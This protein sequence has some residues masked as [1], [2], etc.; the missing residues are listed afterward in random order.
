FLGSTDM[1][2]FAPIINYQEN[3]PGKRLRNWSQYLFWNPSWNFD[4][5]LTFNGV[6]AI[7][8]FETSQFWSFFVRFDWRPPTL[9]DRMTRGGPLGAVPTRKGAQ[10]EF[11]TDRRKPYMFGGFLALST[12]AAGNQSTVIG[13]FLS[14]RPSTA[15]RL[16]LQ[17][18]ISHARDMAQYVLSVDDPTATATYGARYVFATLEQREFA[19]TTR[20][21]WTFTPNVSLQVFAQ[22]LIS[23]GDFFDYK[24]LARPRAYEFRVYGRDGGAIVPDNGGYFVAP[25]SGFPFSFDEPDFNGRFLRG[26]AVLRWE[27][28]PGS[29]LFLVWQQSRSGSIS[30]GDFAFNRDFEGLWSSPPVN[31]FVVKASWWIGR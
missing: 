21:D 26:N 19:M 10:I 14:F 28:R 20:L 6:G 23:A 24:E 8:T 13:P 17:P 16:Q 15:V 18:T 3:K 1:R 31:I 27:Y 5:D 30:R 4:G 11:E 12:N 2:S 22:P 25:A 9:D 29:A 7:T